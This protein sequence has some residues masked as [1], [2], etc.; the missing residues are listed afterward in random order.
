[1]CSSSAAR[2]VAIPVSA[3]VV[4]VTPT[5]R[6]AAVVAVR[7]GL[8][9]A[10]SAASRPVGPNSPMGSRIRRG[11]ST[12]PS[13]STPANSAPPPASISATPCCITAAASRA[14]PAAAGSTASAARARPTP[15]RG[16]A[17][18]S[19]RSAASGLTRSTRR[20]GDQAAATVTTRPTA[21]PPSSH[22]GGGA[23]ATT[24]VSGAT[25]SIAAISPYPRA[26][27]ATAPAR[28]ANV[29]T[30]AASRRTER[31]TC[32]RVAPTQ[33]SSAKSRRRCANRMANVFVTTTAATKTAT[34]ANSSSITPTLSTWFCTAVSRSSA[35]ASGDC[36]FPPG[37]SVPASPRTA[38]EPRW[39][40]SRQ[41]SSCGQVTYTSACAGGDG[42]STRP[43]TRT[44]AAAAPSPITSRS[45]IETS[46][47]RAKC[48]S[49]TASP[50]RTAK[51]PDS[52][53]CQRHRSTVEIGPTPASGIRRPPARSGS[54]ARPIADAFSP[55]RSANAITSSGFM[56]DAGHPTGETTRSAFRYGAP[57]RS[58]SAARAPAVSTPTTTTNATA[59]ATA[60]TAAT[61]LR[62]WVR[63]DAR[64]TVRIRR[65]ARLAW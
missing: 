52:S 7:R 24:G 1:M 54:E 62:R 46:L 45:P 12:G 55:S 8:R 5:S 22:D 17:A 35:N 11:T 43:T 39:R 41:R 29:P 32:R 58:M 51:R 23:A 53:G 21:T 64:K 57:R 10:F 25:R 42:D 2:Q 14:N 47:A 13:R 59:V 6:A 44:A 61:C 4:R 26:A 37:G 65:S 56:C 27:P 36:A 63:S 9:A 3:A 28:D 20:V 33:R 15:V 16:P 38:T 49:A 50:P 48:T 60:T 40:R 19:G 18:T 34:P 31:A 30:A